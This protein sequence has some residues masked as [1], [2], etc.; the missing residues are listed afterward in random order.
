MTRKVISIMQFNALSVAKLV[1]S[2]VVGV[3]AG[4]IVK[5]II[6]HN[7]DAP[8]TLIDKVSLLAG[9]WVLSGIVTTATKKYT[10]EAIDDIAKTVVN[11]K[12]ALQL[13]S[14]IDR[15]NRGESTI[16]GEGL[17]PQKYHWD[18]VTSRVVTLVEETDETAKTES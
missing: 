18:P 17:D 11:L 6:K 1:T 14:K 4:K 5:N 9:G 7:V 16:A 13:K 15:I 3:G 8:E 10:D 12:K 2:T